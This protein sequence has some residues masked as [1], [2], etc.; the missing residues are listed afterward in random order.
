MKKRSILGILTIV[1]VL[2]LV[3]TGCAKKAEPAPAPAPAPKQ[4]AAK[5]AE[6]KKEEAKKDEAKTST[7]E[8]SISEWKGSW[9]NM[10]AYLDDK[11]LQGAFETLAKKENKS[12]DEVKKA[13][14]EKRKCE[15]DGFVVDGDKVTLLDAFQDKN[16]KVIS[17]SEYVFNKAYNVK[18]G[19]YDLEWF[20]YEAKGEAKYKVLLMMEVHG[21]EALTH[22]HMRYGDDVDKLLAIDGWYPTFVKPNSTYDQLIA[23]ITE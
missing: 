15:F 21:E 1:L 22:F 14:V 6:E 18:H 3:F 17:E 11:E 4:E 12:V 2:S 13:Y 8:N 5:P 19:N 9:N 10:G 16:G 20:A 23:E 7:A